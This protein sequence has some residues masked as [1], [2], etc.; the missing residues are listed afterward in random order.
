MFHFFL[1]LSSL[2]LYF[3]PVSHEQGELGWGHSNTKLYFHFPP[4]PVN[5]RTL[6]FFLPV[7]HV[8]LPCYLSIEIKAAYNS[9]SGDESIFG[10]K[11]TFNHNIRIK[12]ATTHY[13]ISEGDGFINRYTRE[14]NL[15]EATET[16]VQ[17]ILIAQKK[18]DA[19]KSQLKDGTV[20]KELEKRLK[21]DKA[22]REEMAEKLIKVARP[23]GPGKYY[24][25]A[26]GQSVLE[27]KPDGSYERSFQNG[28]KEFFNRNG[29]LIRSQDRNGNYLTYVYQEEDLIRINDM[30][31][32]NV[33]FV[34]HKTGS[35]KGLVK[36]IQD[37]LGRVWNY[38]FD[39]ARNL[40]SFVAPG[41]KKTE[42]RYDKYGNIIEVKNT[43][44]ADQNIRLT[45]NE[46]LEVQTQIGPGNN[47]T[48]Y[49]R[50]FVANNPNH[51]ITEI[52]KFNGT[53]FAGR[54][55]HE[56]KVGE[57]ELVTKFDA[58]GKEVS[59]KT[60][61]LSSETGY[62]VSILDEKGFGDLFRY[63]AETGN[64]LHRESVPSG[65]SIDFTYNTRCNQVSTVTIKKPNKAPLV[66]TYKF[67]PHCNVIEAIETQNQKRTGWV[68]VEYTG[69]GKTKFLRDRKNKKEIA[70]TYWQYGKPESITL[71]DIGTLLVKYEPNGE[72]QS[73]E[74]FPHGKGKE[75]FKNQEKAQY[76]SIILQEVR[77]ALDSI[78]S[79]LRPAGLNIGI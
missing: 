37:S 34:Y 72:I 27:K 64:L 26:R 62:P 15:E 10:K 63:D 59:K 11:W 46:K 47:K 73:V 21:E 2:S 65:E 44:D 36:S 20:Y 4:D 32:R 1:L 12:D 6:N 39:N 66:T 50:S 29:R 70:F 51:S 9:Y 79:Y 41:A 17:Q 3:Y 7:D 61:K 74:T 76:Q 14:R 35:I 23:L 22:Y 24:S 57:Y 77:T 49:K 71:R 52:T 18:E 30:C 53:Q 38:S 43:A 16:L 55:I 19:Q 75:R 31:G 28:S 67:D 25:L 78:L 60:K 48:E 56:F 33:S 58:S 5:V 42:Y 40:V 68:T 54:E 45:Y 13:E 69:Q 8:S